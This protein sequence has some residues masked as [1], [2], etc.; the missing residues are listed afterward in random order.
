MGCIH[1]PLT[2]KPGESTLSM[3][4]EDQPPAIANDGGLKVCFWQLQISLCSG[5]KSRENILRLPQ[6]QRKAC[7]HFQH[8][9][10]EAR[11]FCSDSN[12]N[13]ITE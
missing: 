8:P 3:L 13:K 5:L 4:E 12:Q 7:F 10:C 2:N 1:D 11:V 9:L 6:K